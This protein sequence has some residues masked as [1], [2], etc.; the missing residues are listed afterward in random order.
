VEERSQI[1]GD[2]GTGV[3]D[4]MVLQPLRWQRCRGTGAVGVGQVWRLAVFETNWSS[5]LLELSH[6]GR[7]NRGSLGGLIGD[8]GRGLCGLRGFAECCDWV[9][10][11][12]GVI[13]P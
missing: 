9:W 10:D 7:K 2:T 5:F 6:E 1:P 8:N 13:R 3:D 11:F 12:P 4:L